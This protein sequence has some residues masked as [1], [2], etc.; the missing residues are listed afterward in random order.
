MFSENGTDP[1]EIHLLNSNLSVLYLSNLD[2]FHDY[3]IL[4]NFIENDIT[5]WLWPNYSPSVYFWTPKLPA[6]VLLQTYSIS[7]RGNASESSLYIPFEH[8]QNSRF[9]IRA[10][11]NDPTEDGTWVVPNWVIVNQTTASIQIDPKNVSS[12]GIKQLW[13]QAQLITGAIK[14]S[15]A[16]DFIVT[17]FV[18]FN[19]INKNWELVSSPTDI[20][21]IVNK[22]NTFDV[23]FSDE[24]NDN[25]IMKIVDSAGLGVY[26][27]TINTTYFQVYLNCENESIKSAT[28][29]FSSTDIYHTDATY[30][31]NFSVNVNVFLS[32][33]PEYTQ[34][35]QNITINKCSKTLVTQVLPSIVDPDSSL[36]EISFAEQVPSWIYISTL[37]ESGLNNYYINVD[38]TSENSWQSYS[39]SM[40]LTVVLSDNSGAWTKYPFSINFESFKDIKFDHIDDINLSMSK[41]VQIAVGI[42]NSQFY[43]EEWG[44]ASIV[45]WIWYQSNDNF[46]FVFDQAK[47]GFTV[48]NVSILKC[49]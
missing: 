25:I 33:P 28:L 27:K 6:F 16:N 23:I 9:L 49:I 10:W 29:V 21:V 4:A 5:S 24:E 44:T 47:C 19:F 13:L 30:W 1:N 7:V 43:A 12:A 48:G 42:G 2:L 46:V 11:A 36:F 41:P 38:W 45:N 18:S 14:S 32:E 37:T 31:H 40:P 8:W 3:Q 17:N 35:I 34:L 22:V 39:I 15:I 26:I 20:F